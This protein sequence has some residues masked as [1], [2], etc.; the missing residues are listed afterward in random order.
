VDDQQRLAYLAGFFD[1]E[2]CVYI[3][4]QRRAGPPA[5]FSL[6]ISFTGSDV[7][8]LELAQVCFGGQISRSQDPRL[9]RKPVHRLRVRSKQAA[10]A[11]EAMLPYLLVKATRAR[12]AVEFQRATSAPRTTH[13]P[14]VASEVAL[15][16]KARITA[17]NDKAPGRK[18]A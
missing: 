3:L 11:L 7:V 16:F 15:D 2:G 18:S 8:P 6:E 17:M 1:G 5:Q 10:A 14:T 13:G 4:Q 12:I 9:D